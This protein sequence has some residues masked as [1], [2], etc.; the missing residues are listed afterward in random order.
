MLNGPE[1]EA[2]PQP[3]YGRDELS[4]NRPIPADNDVTYG[5]AV[6]LAR[7]AKMSSRPPPGLGAAS[8]GCQARNT[9]AQEDPARQRMLE[10]ERRLAEL[11]G[12]GEQS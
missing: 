5:P 2:P 7:A 11:E 9:E 1:P 12:R 3:F 8:S 4:T 6:G 10:V